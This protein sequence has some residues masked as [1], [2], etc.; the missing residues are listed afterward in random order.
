MEPP[1]PTLTMGSP[2]GLLVL[3]IVRI[4]FIVVMDNLLLYELFFSCHHEFISRGGSSTITT[5]GYEQIR[6]ME[7]QLTVFT[8]TSN[9]KICRSKMDLRG[10]FLRSKVIGLMARY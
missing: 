2:L 7:G 10:V 9:Q 1:Q 4:A 8:T 3:H 5:Q 6:Y